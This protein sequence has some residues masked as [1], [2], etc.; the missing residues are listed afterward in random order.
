HREEGGPEGG[1]P[2][3]RWGDPGGGGARCV[4]PGRKRRAAPLQRSIRSPGCPGDVARCIADRL[5]RRRTAET[6]D[7]TET[8]R[9]ILMRP[10]PLEAGPP[11]RFKGRARRLPAA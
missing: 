3:L 9:P 8:Y 5:R 4:C 10:R 1:D 7:R 11:G 6:T 2:R